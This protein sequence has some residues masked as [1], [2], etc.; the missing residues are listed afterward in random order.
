[1][2]QHERKDKWVVIIIDAKSYVSERKWSGTKIYTLQSHVER[3]RTAYVE[4]E[5]S[6]QHVTE[7]IPNQPTQ[8]KNFLDSVEVCTNL[9]FCN[10]VS[11]VSNKTNGMSNNVESAGAHILPACPVAANI[12]SKRNNAQ[13]SNLGGDFK[14]GTSP[15]TGIQLWYYKSHDYQKLPQKEKDEL[16][17]LCPFTMEITEPREM[18]EEKKRGAATNEMIMEMEMAKEMGEHRRK[19]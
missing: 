11:A 2:D 13:I 16:I 19:Y 3:C 17:N 5:T 7:Q 18:S 6:P 9:K 15:R 8:V 14:T 4:I 1:M 12:G 10:R